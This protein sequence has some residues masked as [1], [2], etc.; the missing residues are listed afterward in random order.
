MFLP[1]DL[2]KAV[3]SRLTVSGKKFE[4][5]V[6]PKGALKLKKGGK[7]NIEDILA[8]PAIYK[9]AR[10]TD[11]VAEK[12]LQ[13]AFG[14][15]DVYKISEQII[16][17]GELQLTTEQRREM[18]EQKKTQIVAI[19]SK[20]G[21][22][23]QTGTPHPPQRINNALAEAGVVIDPFTDAEMQVDK[24]VEA[25]R[26]IVPIKFETVVV[27]VKVQPQY[28]GRV[29]SVI[30]SVG[31]VVKEDWLNDGSLRIN[32][33]VLGGMQNELFEKLSALTHGNFESKIITKEDM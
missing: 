6:D 16:K 8:Y 5:L 11:V 4:I 1:V 30:K 25:I 22:N 13:Q 2:D 28:A 31:S 14:T 20:R 19:I 12:D 10:S 18:V 26:S 27:Q 32:V 7:V 23:P 29:Y 33:K 3:I 21:V 24:V 15:T 17:R 9:D